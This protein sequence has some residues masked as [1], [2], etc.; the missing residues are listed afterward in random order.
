LLLLVGTRKRIKGD[1]QT[2]KKFLLLYLSPVSAEQQMQNASPEDMQKGMEPWVRW[3]D[4]NK[5]AMVEMGT[6]TGNEMNVT[7]AGSSRPTTFI[8]GY[9][10]VQAEDMDAVKAVLSDHPH[11]M[12]EGNSIEVLELMPMPGM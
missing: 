6:P 10:I 7:K 5:Q 3:F 8:G 12:M 11:Y 2:M 1:A 4:T 9:S